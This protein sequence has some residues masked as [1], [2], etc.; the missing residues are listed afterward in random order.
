MAEENNIENLT[1]IC[2]DCATVLPDLVKKLSSDGKVSVVLDPPRKGCDYSVLDAIKSCK[3]DKIVYIS[4]NPATLARDVGLLTG[5]LKYDGNEIKKVADFVPEY[6][7]TTVQPY[8]MFAQT[9]HVESLVCL[10][11]K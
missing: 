4:C 2:G 1:N 3:I 11:R 7:I 6:E 10:T 5:S 9:K 8:D